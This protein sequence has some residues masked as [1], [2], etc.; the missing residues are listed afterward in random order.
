MPACASGWQP[1]LPASPGL[2]AWRYDAEVSVDV[3]LIVRAAD[4]RLVAVLHRGERRTWTCP[5]GP[6]EPRLSS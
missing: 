2:R 1:A 6:Q 5:G 3:T 4:G